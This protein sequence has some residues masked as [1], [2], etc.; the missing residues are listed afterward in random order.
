[1]RAKANR[2]LGFIKRICGKDI[3]DQE[4]RKLLYIT[5][6]RSKIEY[7]SNLWSPCTA[8]ERAL[9]ENIQRRGTTMG[10]QKKVAPIKI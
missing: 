6:V 10:R 8:K 7:A 1:M 9:I 4:T 2:T 3:V 5:I